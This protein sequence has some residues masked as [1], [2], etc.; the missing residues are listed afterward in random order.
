MA[1]R[2]VVFISGRGSNLKALLENQES[3]EVVCVLSNKP[4][5]E[6]LEYAR[7]HRVPTFTV[8]KKEAGSIGAQKEKLYEHALSLEPEFVLLA[9]YMQIVEPEFI[10]ELPGRILNVHPSLLP[11]FPGL[12][13]HKQA[14]E[15]GEQEHGCTVHVVTKEVDA[16]PIIAQAKVEVRP[17]D[18]EESLAARVL[19]VEHQVYPTVLNSFGRIGS[20]IFLDRTN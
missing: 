18:T 14:L 5:A 20:F 9:G 3:F 8:S 7:E 6:G 1:C 12:N 10:D 15:A 11:K 19:K 2:V 13:P 17:D 16:G 4:E